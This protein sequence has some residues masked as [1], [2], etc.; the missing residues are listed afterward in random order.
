MNMPNQVTVNNAKKNFLIWLPNYTTRF[1]DYLI[2]LHKLLFTKRLVNLSGRCDFSLIILDMLMRDRS[3]L[4][5]NF[6]SEAITTK[7][8]G[9]M[10]LI[11]EE[12]QQ[13]F[14]F[15]VWCFYLSFD[16]GMYSQGHDQRLIRYSIYL[17]IDC[18]I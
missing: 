14:F 9:K 17:L 13:R 2:I 16:I 4:A 1:S 12:L 10:V 7:Q 6:G 15:C 18:M 8:N 5:K 11:P 3:L